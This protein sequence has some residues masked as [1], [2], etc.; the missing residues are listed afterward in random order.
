MTRQKEMETLFLGGGGD[1][2]VIIALLTTSQSPSVSNLEAV[3][4]LVAW[5]SLRP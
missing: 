1:G 2:I 4:R 3:K 5:S